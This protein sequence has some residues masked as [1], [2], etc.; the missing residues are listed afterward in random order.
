MHRILVAGAAAVCL[1]VE[2]AGPASAASVPTSVTSVAAQAPMRA[3]TSGA[4][5][6]G[7]GAQDVAFVGKSGTNQTIAQQP[8]RRRTP[9]RKKRRS[10]I[11][12]FFGALAFLFI[13]LPLLLIVALVLFVMMRRGRKQREQ[14]LG[15]RQQ[16]G[17]H[18]GYQPGP[19]PG[20]NGQ[21][22]D[23]TR[24]Y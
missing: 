8:E 11:G 22:Q 19:Y 2:G 17:N 12:R 9:Y 13:G 21:D 1:L 10:G 20:A 23:P 3:A 7:A 16:Y 14:A 18:Q 24:R 15:Q 4:V 6:T 5:S